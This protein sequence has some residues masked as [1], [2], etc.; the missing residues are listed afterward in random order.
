MIIKEAVEHIY[1]DI[2]FGIGGDFIVEQ[3]GP[4]GTAAIAEWTY[5]QPQP[6]V[7][8]LEAA[9]AIVGIANAKRDA[10]EKVL[11]TIDTFPLEVFKCSAKKLRIYERKQALVNSWGGESVPPKPQAEWDGDWS[12]RAEFT[13][14]GWVA[15][16]ALGMKFQC[17]SA[18]DL[19]QTWRLNT[20]LANY[21]DEMSEPLRTRAQADIATAVDEAAI[22]AIVTQFTA[23]IGSLPVAFMTSEAPALIAASGLI[24][25]S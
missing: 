4:D 3:Y 2:K 23:D 14:N 6:T 20:A 15:V 11:S 16:E 19:W 25:V 5:S 22:N 21:L 10:N 12:R 8:E 13:A 18:A 9:W 17:T 1:P 24:P 7:S